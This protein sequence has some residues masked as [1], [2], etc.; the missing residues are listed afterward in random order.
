M[1]QRFNSKNCVT[2]FKF[3]N[4][5]KKSQ[6]VIKVISHIL[7]KTIDHKQ[8]N[9]ENFQGARVAL[10]SCSIAHNSIY[11][12]WEP[13]NMLDS[14]QSLNTNALFGFVCI[15]K[16]TLRH[17]RHHLKIFLSLPPEYLNF[18][19]HKKFIHDHRDSQH[20]LLRLLKTVF[21]SSVMIKFGH[22]K[23]PRDDRDHKIGRSRKIFFLWHFL[24]L[25]H[26]LESLLTTQ[27]WHSICT[28]V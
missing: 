23:T 28:D 24:L 14:I 12:K 17:P 11:Q 9:N 25:L 7:S 22:K 21:F 6:P 10:T 18:S 19:T 3:L 15:M 20:S 2:H 8:F 13:Q 26:R 1:S 16:S 27:F 5:F 4:N